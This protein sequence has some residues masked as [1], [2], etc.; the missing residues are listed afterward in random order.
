MTFPK[1]FIGPMSQ[2]VIDSVIEY[3]SE[4]NVPLGLIPSRR[5]I[6]FCTGYVNNWTTSALSAYVRSRTDLVYL[7]RDHG[8]PNQG[9]RIDAGYD[10]F[11]DD[12]F[13]LDI[14]H[15]D[16][17]KVH[18]L[19]DAAERTLHYIKFCYERNPGLW[20]EVGTEQAIHEYTA[21]ELENTIYYFKCALDSSIYSRIKYAVIQSGTSIKNGQNTGQYSSDRL[22]DML[23]V[24]KKYD[25]LSKEHNGDYLDSSLIQE[26]FKLGLD[27]INIAPEFGQIES[28]IL[29]SSIKAEKRDDLLDLFY[30][31]C[32]E[33]GKWK[34]WLTNADDKEQVIKATGHYVFSHPQFV[35]IRESF[36]ADAIIKQ[37]MKNR[38]HSIVGSK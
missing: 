38:I 22:S 24:C 19:E 5:Q 25:M 16:P 36:D 30:K 10:S 32:F 37:S 15:I 14:I 12:C 17:W 9:E 35:Q 6:D 34:K 33:S 21:E 7:V 23:S 20:F 29:L 28:E 18:D 2:N 27:A 8:G 13:N 4:H 1:L 11:Y 26:K 3:S 31:L